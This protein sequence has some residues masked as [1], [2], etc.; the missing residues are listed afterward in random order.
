MNTKII[1]IA[2][3]EIGYKEG[4]NNDNKYGIWY[5]MNHASWCN[6]F[7]SWCAHNAKIGTNIIPK[8][9]YVPTTLKWFKNNKQYHE[10][11]KYTP[12]TGDIIFFDNNYNKEVDHIG[13][14]E[15]LSGNIVYTIEGNADDMVKRKEYELSSNKI[16]GYG[17]PKYVKEPDVNPEKDRIRELQKLLGVVVDGIYGKQTENAVNKAGIKKGL[18]GHLVK[19]TQKQLIRHKYHLI[20]GEDGVF[21]TQTDKVVKEFQKSKKEVADGWVGARTMGSLL[22]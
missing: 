4:K 15:K 8:E 17:V 14:V 2:K 18:K 6:I 9:A 16:L 5:G 13:L 19:F 22:K 20:G 7:V 1:N 12:N 10:R 3:E 21:G 11:G